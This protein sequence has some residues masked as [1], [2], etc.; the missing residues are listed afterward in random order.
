V[1]RVLGTAAA[2]AATGYMSRVA[3]AS[4]SRL[5]GKGR[6]RG[7]TAALAAA[8]A[9]VAT[10]E[11]PRA[12]VA[13]GVAVL[14]AAAALLGTLGRLER[15]ARGDLAA[16]VA[17]ASRSSAT[18]LGPA[19]RSLSVVV[20]SYNEEARLPA[21]LDAILAY[22]ERRARAGGFT[23]EVL[24]VDDGSTDGT[25]GVAAGYAARHG[26]GQVRVLRQPRNGG[27]GRAVK[28]GVLAS[29]GRRVLMAD[30]DGATRFDDLERLERA[31]A[32]AEGQAAA[33]GDA[34]A[35]VAVFGS[36]RGAERAAAR[37][38]LAW[39]FRALA[40]AAA[41]GGGGGVWDTQCGFKLFNRRAAQVLFGNL[42]LQGWAADVEL[43]LLAAR[44]GARV[45]EVA[46]EWRE[47]PGSKVHPVATPVAMAG[48]LG[49]LWA[50]YRATGVFR[51]LGVPRAVPAAGGAGE[52]RRAGERHGRGR[53]G[54]GGGP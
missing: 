8:S 40:R 33:E 42:R 29:R 50:G 34:G 19:G 20:P 26:W 21:A 15:T 17:A 1:P 12:P 2:C 32:A 22:L 5:A 37:G 6:C 10:G 23:W 45:S 13:L 38:A 24:V 54:R 31:M 11:A 44:T 36:R 53:G 47:V 30:A 18:V 43:L 41:G 48:E 9:L 52:A 49:L 14:A 51:P 46:V 7:S 3:S 16:L 27:K 4:P 25:F 39:G 35:P 28:A